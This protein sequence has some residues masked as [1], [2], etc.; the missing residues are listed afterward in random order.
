MQ[1][2]SEHSCVV[3]NVLMMPKVLKIPNMAVGI[4]GPV[5]VTNA[6]TDE[7]SVRWRDRDSDLQ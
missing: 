1:G 7:D 2:K 4:A 6:E 5:V 3:I